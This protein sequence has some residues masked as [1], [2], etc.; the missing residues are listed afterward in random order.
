MDAKSKADFFNSIVEGQTIPCPKCNTANKPD[1]QFCMTCGA[2]L[3][4]ATEKNNTP[5]FASVSENQQQ[6]TCGEAKYSEVK[7]VFAEGLPSWDIIPPQ[8]IVRRR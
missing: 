5:A 7:S 2:K 6:T 3:T 8:V 4:K 1:A